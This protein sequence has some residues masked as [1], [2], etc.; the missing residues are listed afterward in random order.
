MAPPKHLPPLDGSINVL[1]GFVDFHA[2][3]NSLLPWV[4]FPA[5]GGARSVTFLE[6]SR[7]THRIAHILKPGR[8]GLE[9]EIVAVLIHTDSVMYLTLLVGMIRAGLVVRSSMTHLFMADDVLKA[10]PN[11]AS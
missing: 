4:K 9:G 5:Q 10:V 6:L 11:V 8:N 3:H 2:E 1:P 7:A